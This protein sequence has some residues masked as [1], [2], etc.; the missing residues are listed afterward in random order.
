[1]NVRYSPRAISDIERMAEYLAD[2]SVVAPAIVGAAIESTV[3][4]LGE[5]PKSGRVLEQRPKVRVIPLGRFPYLVFYTIH[6]GQVVIL[7]IRHGARRSI[8]HDEL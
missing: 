2:K 1:M 5:F 7:H 8:S 4:L 6:D 3:R